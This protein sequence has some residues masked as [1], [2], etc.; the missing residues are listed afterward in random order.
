MTSR[1]PQRSDEPP[2][3]ATFE[4]TAGG[5]WPGRP[6][7]LPKPPP[8]P[9]VGVWQPVAQYD[10]VMGTVLVWLSWHEYSRQIS[11]MQECGRWEQARQLQ[12]RS[13]PDVSDGHPNN[14]VWVYAQS[15]VPLEVTCRV[16]HFCGVRGPK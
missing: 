14:R 7:S 8:V 1:P 13:N 2:E 3:P 16:T 11:S 12:L 4:V 15:G 5:S 9:T 10:I 6:G